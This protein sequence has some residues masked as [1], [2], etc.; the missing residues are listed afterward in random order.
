MKKEQDD[1]KLKIKQSLNEQRKSRLKSFVRVRKNVQIKRWE[2]GEEETL[3]ENGSKWRK[4]VEE[5]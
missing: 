2:I 3:M 4:E 1:N 5:K